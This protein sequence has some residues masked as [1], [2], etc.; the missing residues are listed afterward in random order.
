MLFD[1]DTGHHSPNE[2]E[3][4][5]EDGYH[6]DHNVHPYLGNTGGI[7]SSRFV[8]AESTTVKAV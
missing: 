2:A 1:Q 8:V 4:Q 3:D 7:N 6:S 5:E